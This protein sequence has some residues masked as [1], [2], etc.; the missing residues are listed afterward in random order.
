MQQLIRI[1]CKVGDTCVVT[2]FTCATEE[3]KSDNVFRTS[4]EI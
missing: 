4:D 3:L 1:K 2:S